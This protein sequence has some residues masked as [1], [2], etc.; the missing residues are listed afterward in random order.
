[1]ADEVLFCRRLTQ[2]LFY[3]RI[4]LWAVLFLSLS[5]GTVG[6]QKVKAVLLQM[7]DIYE[8]ASIQ[9]GKSGGM[10]RV[11]TLRKQL[12]Q[13][14]PNTVTVV[15]GDF[16]SPSVFNLLVHDNKK[17]RGAQM[18]E[19]LNAVPVD[20]VTFG[21]HEFDITGEELQQRLN[22]SRFEWIATNT[23]NVNTKGVT[24]PFA[25]QINGTEMPLPEYKIMTFTGKDQSKFRLGI[26]G[27]TLPYTKAPHVTYEDVIGSAKRVY[28]T[29]KDSCDAVIALT[30]QFVHEDE[31]LAKALPELKLLMGGH[32][33]THKYLKVG[34]TM[35]AKADA[36][37]RTVY[38]HE[39]IFD[40][41]KKTLK[42]KS[43]LK[44]ITPKLKDDPQT[45]EVVQ[46]WTNIAYASFRERGFEPTEVVYTTAEPLEGTEAIIR[47][48][49]TNLGTI[50]AEA[51][52][53][54]GDQ[55]DLAVFNSGSVRIDDILM[56]KITQYDILRTLPFGG[57][58]V[59]AD[60]KGSVLRQ[61]L[62]A[63]EKNKGTGGYLQMM[64]VRYDAPRQIWYIKEEPLTD[65]KQ[66]RVLISEYM[67]SG[68][69]TNLAF[70]NQNNPDI[71]VVTENLDPNKVELR[72]DI[73]KV[74][75]E[76]LKK[77]R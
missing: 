56:D 24:Q 10:A 64:N 47:S 4:L 59:Q 36:N 62:E 42:I 23:K 69:E 21:N 54:A 26:I 72:K 34:T 77:K 76:Y 7:N 63:G 32:E 9:G 2:E 33:H 6:A 46:K 57:S 1:M 14:N 25:R 68:K 37:A 16:L 22:E 43:K 20:L 60:V 51:M 38:V 27:L 44:A 17:V 49:P 67:F 11:A 8:I 66:Y 31:A 18:T 13:K 35:I 58:I 29:I 52:H 53:A 75:L 12:L 40:A 71:K 48:Q 61:I 50:I 30:H 73:R 55:A 39:F 65:Y 15:A 45:A 70:V 28:G 3:M 41:K 19:V 74:V 5:S